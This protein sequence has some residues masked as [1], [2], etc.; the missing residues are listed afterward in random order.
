ML[1]GAAVW[2]CLLLGGVPCLAQNTKIDG[3]FAPWNRTNSPGAA[4][5][6]LENGT[7]RYQQ[8]FGAANLELGIPI[9]SNTVFDAASVAKQFTGLATAMLVEQGRIRLDEEVRHYLPDVP[10]FGRVITVSHLL[11]HTSGLRDWPEV[12]S[13]SGMGMGDRITFQAILEMVRRQRDLD[14]VPGEKYSYSNTG[15]NLLAAIIAKVTG[16]SFANWTQANLF[17]PLGMS[18]TRF[19]DDP[20]ALV[21]NGAESYT[22]ASWG[23]F[24]KAGNQLAAPG[25]SSLFT[26]ITDLAKWMLNFESGAAGGRGAIEAMHL[27]SKANSGE[28]VRYGFGLSLGEFHGLKT[29]D[30]TGGWAGFRSVVFRIPEK[31][32]GVAILS[33][34]GN[35][36]TLR[37]ARKIAEICLDLAALPKV[38]SSPAANEKP[39]TESS[40]AGDWQ[41]YCGTY[42]LQPGWLL[43]I[44]LENGHLM[45]RAS[46]EAKF[47]MEF[48]AKDCFMV[49]AYNAPI[50]FERDGSG[51]VNSLLYRGLHAPRVTVPQMNAEQLALFAG[52]YWSEEL[53]VAWRLSFRQGRLMAWHGASGWVGF[54]PSDTDCFDLDNGLNLQFIRTAGRVTGFKI[55]GQ[56][57][58]NLRFDKR[59][60]SNP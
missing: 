41:A 22:P 28:L 53:L 60:V 14:F 26:T 20:H 38:E 51:A 21:L 17:Q 45:T 59:T 54:T 46:R 1:A 57:V 47:G 5:V 31:R 16:Q 19:L 15:Y 48:T 32:F 55:S 7:V 42:R 3:L 44:T 4:V 36:D 39:K 33:N 6:V 2:V 13:V 52:D 49:Q 9:T 56:R 30:H 29:V 34:A 18:Q 35:L 40:A 24:H 27:P 50:Q 10:D 11:H 23:G 37:M 12:F 25:S 58:K 8:C 43:T